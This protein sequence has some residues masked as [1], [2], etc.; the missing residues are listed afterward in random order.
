MN[1]LPFRLPAC[2][3]ALALCLLPWAKPLHAQY[4]SSNANYILIPFFTG[5]DSGYTSLLWVTNTS[6]NPW[7]VPAQNATCLVDAYYQGVRY[8]PARLPTGVANNT[9]PA[10]TAIMLTE[11]Q[12]AAVTGLSLANSGQRAYLYLTCNNP[13]VSAQMLFINPGGVV[14]FWPGQYPPNA[15]VP[16]TI[17]SPIPAT[18]LAGP[19]V[20]F[21]WTPGTAVQHYELEVSAKAVGGSELF[22]SG[23]ISATQATVSGIPTTGGTI[24]VRLNFEVNGLWMATD[25][26]F[27]EY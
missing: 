16:P 3:L 20:Q 13:S 15:P 25:Y 22:N 12:I 26:T 6:L 21:Q 4:P 17:T 7:G 24:Y 19:I 9:V 5:T 14:T 10:G 11:A 1:R 23:S 8:G 27:S 2:A 18:T